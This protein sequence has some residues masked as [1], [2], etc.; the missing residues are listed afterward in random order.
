MKSFVP[1]YQIESA[2]NLRSALETLSHKNFKVIAGGTDVM[3][4]FEAGKLAEGKYLDV[5]RVPEL[6]G[7]QVNAEFIELGALTTYREILENKTLQAEFTMLC[8]AAKL[9]GAVAIQNR[10]TIG[11]NIVNASP[12]A[13]SPP[14]L[15]AYDTDIE[16]CSLRGSRWVRYVDFHKDY[17]KMDKHEDEL[18]TKIRIKRNTQSAKQ[19]YHKVGTRKAQAISKV[20]MAALAQV[21]QGTITKFR[22]GLGSIAAIPFR[23]QKT[24]KVLEGRLLSAE[25]ISKSCDILFKEI[26]PIDD[27][28][29]NAE[30]RK[31]VAKNLLQ[32]FL[33]TL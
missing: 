28:R 32:T 20:C 33:E 31:T 5:W 21:E 12:A 29:S 30:Y 27:I 6:K 15:L 2:Q 11:G 13:D 17:K 3:V 16:L 8:Q 4:L 9:T 1:D 23:A 18:L 22:L 26:T 25:L 19:Y 14:A 7:I 10:G 24:E